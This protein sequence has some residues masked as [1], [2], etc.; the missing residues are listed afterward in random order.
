MESCLGNNLSYCP[1]QKENLG[2]RMKS[3]FADSFKLIFSKVV[4]IVI[5]YPELNTEIIRNAFKSLDKND[6]ILGKASD[7]GY[8]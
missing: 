6:S 8:Y 5:D 4:I 1:Q 3:A 7:G 2:N